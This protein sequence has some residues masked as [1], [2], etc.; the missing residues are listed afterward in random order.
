MSSADDGL[1]GSNTGYGADADAA[2]AAFAAALALALASSSFASFVFCSLHQACASRSSL[3][4]S[5][6][7]S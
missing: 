7:N 3:I 2:V 6:R 5:R 4:P 1:G